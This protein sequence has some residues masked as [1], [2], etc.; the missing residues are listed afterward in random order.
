M[1]PTGKKVPP[2]D[3]KQ[4][5]PRKKVA[6]GNKHLT[7]KYLTVFIITKSVVEVSEVPRR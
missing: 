3:N 1:H 4:A 5:H 7:H 6:S 2:M